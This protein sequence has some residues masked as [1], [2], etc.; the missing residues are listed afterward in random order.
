METVKRV[1]ESTTLII[2]EAVP[3]LPKRSNSFYRGHKGDFGEKVAREFGR[4]A[5]KTP[6]G[7]ALADMQIAHTPFQN[8]QVAPRI[9]EGSLDPES[10]RRALKTLL[11]HLGA[12]IAG[13]C[14][15]KRYAWYSHDYRGQADRYLSPQRVGRGDRPGF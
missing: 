13:T 11:H 10:N 4:F 12:D 3:R 8:G 6:V 9:D 14:E 7:M 15:A 2:D 1:D 5:I